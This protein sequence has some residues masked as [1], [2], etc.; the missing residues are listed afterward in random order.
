MNFEIEIMVWKLIWW[1]NKLENKS[2][3]FLENC[4]NC[5]KAK[6]WELE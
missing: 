6:K 5:W 1:W 4:K 2:Q 3:K